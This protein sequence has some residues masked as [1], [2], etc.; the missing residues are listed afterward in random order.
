M[1]YR[2]KKELSTGEYWMAEKHLKIFNNYIQ[3][4]SEKL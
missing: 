4:S 1:A 2:F 3:E